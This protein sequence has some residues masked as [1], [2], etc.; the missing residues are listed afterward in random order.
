[1]YECLWRAI[2]CIARTR[3]CG[4][5]RSCAGMDDGDPHGYKRLRGYFYECPDDGLVM[6]AAMESPET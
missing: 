4:Y 1:M 6:A 2:V 5:G 3:F